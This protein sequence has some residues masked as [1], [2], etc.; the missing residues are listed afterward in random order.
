MNQQPVVVGVDG[1]AQ[2][3]RAAAIAWR[4]ARAGNVSCSLVCA[5]P[6]LWTPGIA[7]EIAIAPS[8]FD[9]LAA[10]VRRQ[11]AADVGAEIPAAVRD[12]L[13]FRTG[14]PGPVLLAFAREKGADLIVVGARRRG[15]LARN[16]GGSTAHYLVRTADAPVLVAETTASAPKRL[17]VAID[18]V[19]AA[20][21]LAAAARY[22]ELLGLHLRALYVAEPTKFPA[23]FAVAADQGDFARRGRAEFERLLQA[24]PQLPSD[25]RV[26]RQG[27]ADE[28]I[29]A[30]AADWKADFLVIGSHGR[31]WI[32]RML[33]GSTTERLLNRL[34]ASLIVVPINRPAT[35]P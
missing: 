11:L 7:G 17:L 28:E 9:Q 30:E 24:L 35:T 19:N 5:I 25:D 23:R 3:S 32:D 31:G 4:I 27:L 6:D 10:E 26:V 12:G 20:P 22:A 14:R 8:L 2:S 21:V 33:I 1:S 18:L 15:V 16:L 34:P 13:V 29:A